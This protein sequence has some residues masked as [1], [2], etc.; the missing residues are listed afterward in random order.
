MA[1]RRGH[2]DI[3]TA[4]AD[5]LKLVTGKAGFVAEGSSEKL[6]P[7]LFIEQVG[8]IGLPIS[9]HEVQRIIGVVR[10]PLFSD[11]NIPAIDADVPNIPAIDADIPNIWEIDPG[12]FSL[13]HPKWLYQ[14]SQTLDDAAKQLG[15][16]SGSRSIKAKL[17]K[18]LIH[19]P[20]AVFKAHTKYVAES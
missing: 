1:G 3:K 14:L 4:I 12:R 6:N 7:G 15:I 13:Q 16:D 18:L 20:G 17:A 9:Q 5:S 8:I 2:L 11:E 10:Q 19:E